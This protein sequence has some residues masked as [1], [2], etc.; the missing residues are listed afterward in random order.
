MRKIIN[1]WQN[2]NEG[3]NKCFGCS[4]QNPNGLQMEFFEDGEHIVSEWTPRPE[5]EGYIDMLHG[6]IQ[7]TILDEVACWVVYIKCKTSGVTSNM[8]IKYRGAVN[9][10]GQPIKARASLIET[11]SR[12]VTI[13]AEILNNEDKVC[14]EA[15]IKYF[16][17]PEKLAQEKYHYPGVE[18]FFEE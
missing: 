8:D 3:P 13:K 7:A 2:K 9:L 12:M 5:F 6:G 1:P 17:F 4:K 16:I 15:V 18:A 11:T 10:N 14:S